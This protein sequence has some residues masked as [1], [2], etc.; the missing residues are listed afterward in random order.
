M[1]PY[2]GALLSGNGRCY[3]EDCEN[4]FHYLK[5]IPSPQRSPLRK[6]SKKKRQ[7]ENETRSARMPAPG[8]QCELCREPAIETHEI[9]AGS[10]RSWAIRIRAAQLRLC[11][12]CHA[13]IQGRPP[14]VQLAQL[15]TAKISA[16][17]FCYGSKRVTADDVIEALK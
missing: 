14:E 16:I 4:E 9:P 17:N 2:C 13:E 3:T 15:I 12:A 1:C 7:E 8:E 11:R 10:G 6:Q 5:S